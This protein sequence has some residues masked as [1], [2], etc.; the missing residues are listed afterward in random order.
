MGWAKKNIYEY[1]RYILTV[2]T[3]YGYFILDLHKRV[4][5]SL[6]FVRVPGSVVLSCYKKKRYSCIPGIWIPV[7]TYQVCSSIP[8]LPSPSVSPRFS[9]FLAVLLSCDRFV[10]VEFYRHAATLVYLF[11]HFFPTF[12]RCLFRAR[13]FVLSVC[14][15]GRYDRTVVGTYDMMVQ[16]NV[17][18]YRHAEP[19]CFS[20]DL[21]SEKYPRARV[22][23]PQ[24][25]FFFG[26]FPR[27]GM[28]KVPVCLPRHYINN[29]KNGTGRWEALLWTGWNGEYTGFLRCG[30]HFLGRNWSVNGL[31]I[32]RGIRRDYNR[33]G[34]GLHDFLVVWDGKR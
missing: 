3:I 4:G 22:M 29:T 2:V 10:P 34:M 6:L 5:K 1:T 25:N 26:V 20:L 14:A 12:L 8:S 19:F 24:A 23:P 18:S 32:G 33:D 31:G 17:G 28:G 27:D 7:R 9:F 11:S 21:K 16:Y 13:V 15:F 30:K